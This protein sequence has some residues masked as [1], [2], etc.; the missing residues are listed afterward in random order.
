[1]TKKSKSKSKFQAPRGMRD[2][3]PEEQLYW[4]KVK[5]VISS[6]AKA[7]EFE[8]IDTPILE[9]KDLF[10]KGTGLYTD[11]VEKEMYSLTT[12]GRDKLVLRPE[13][14][15]SVVRAYLENGLFSLPNPV[16]LY[17]IGPIFRYERPQ[18]GRYRQAYQANFEVIGEQDPII[19]AQLIQLFFSFAK[20]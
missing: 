16:K 10:V 6:S 1:M 2:I 4:E 8:K 3:L 14:T 13:F 12:R 18:K 17:S 19:D 15:P 9:D 5:Q 7:F 20:N 11:I